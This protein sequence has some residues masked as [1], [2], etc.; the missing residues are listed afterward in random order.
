MSHTVRYSVFLVFLAH[1]SRRANTS[2]AC[3]H[4]SPFETN[5]LKD[6]FTIIQDYCE[7][8][9]NAFYFVQL[10]YI[11]YVRLNGAELSFSLCTICDTV[12]HAQQPKSPVAGRAFTPFPVFLLTPPRMDIMA[13]IKIKCIPAGSRGTSPNQCASSG[14]LDGAHLHAISALSM[15]C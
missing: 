10:I 14:M 13:S 1:R 2:D 6:R 3:A 8:R 15:M 7:R 4:Q 9:I 5:P 11:L 12:A